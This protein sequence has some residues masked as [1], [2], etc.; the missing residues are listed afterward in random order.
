MEA[1]A[2]N[3][4]YPVGTRV[5]VTKAN[6]Q[7]VLTRTCGAAVRVG[8]FAMIEVEAIQPGLTL[9]SWCWPVR[10]EPTAR[11]LRHLLPQNSGFFPPARV[12]A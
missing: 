1:T 2:W 5:I 8:Q 3:A 9:L 10:R 7:R 4:R 6:G 11:Q 12:I